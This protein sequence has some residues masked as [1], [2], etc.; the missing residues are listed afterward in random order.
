MA[1]SNAPTGSLTM[2]SHFRNDDARRSSRVLRSSGSTTVG[3]VTTVM[4][5]NRSAAPHAMPA[6]SR[7]ASDASTKLI[8]S[9][10]MV[11]RS[12]PSPA[13]R[14]SRTS[15]ARPPS[16]TTMATARPTSG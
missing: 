4:A 6:H 15:R 13:A 10:T 16:K 9:A 14:S 3:P 7:A 5:P 11:R 12:T 8:G 2:A 1:A